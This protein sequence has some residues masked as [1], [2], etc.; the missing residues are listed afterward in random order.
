MRGKIICGVVGIGL[1][2]AI[3][4]WAQG[5][6]PSPPMDRDMIE[7][8]VPQLHSYYADHKYTVTQ[9]VQWYLDRIKHYDGIYKAVETVMAKEALADAAEEDA[10]R[11]RHSWAALGRAHRDQGQHL[12]RRPDHHQRLGGLHHEGP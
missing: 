6:R 4:V 7:V 3:P 1:C 10:D 8:T 12:H 9:V 2:M 5:A 11:T